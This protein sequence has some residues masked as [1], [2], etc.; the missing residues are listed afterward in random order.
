MA[1]NI[2]NEIAGIDLGDERRNRRIGRLAA[3]MAASPLE[4]LRAACK[5]WAEAIAGFRLLHN[6]EVTWEKILCAHEQATMERAGACERMLL[7][8]DT[9]ELDYSSHKALTGAGRLDA[10]TRQGFYAHNH[11]LVDEDTGVA[12]GLCGSHVWSREQETKDHGHKL[13]PF[14]EKESYRWFQGYQRACEVAKKHPAAEVVTV[15]DRESDIYEIY[16]DWQRRC[17]CG[18]KR[19]EVLVRAGRDRALLDSD[20]HLFQT[21]RAGQELGTYQVKFASK[22]QLRKIK[23]SNHL[24][25]RLGRKAT[26]QVRSTKVCLKPPDRKHGEKLPSVELWAVCILEIDPPQGHE[27]I[28]WFLLTS[29]PAETFSRAQ[30]IISAYASRWLVEELHRILKSGCRVER[31][32]L[33]DSAALLPAV[34]LYLI[35]AWR[36]L[37]L[38]DFRRAQ[39]DLCC[40][41]FFTPAE[42]QAACL[43]S[44]RP[45]DTGPPT[46]VLMVDM[47]G[48]MGGH[49]GRKNDPSPGPEC[50]WRGM[51]KLRCYVEMGQALGKF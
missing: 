33:R 36:I 46:L 35:V 18:E 14:E 1:A 45:T 48:K 43:I 13:V 2:L 7:I 6:K 12:L 49:M 26:L 44:G 10:Q 24:T 19:A 37:Y 8:Q 3:R 27:P 50:L 42:W 39:P 38:R 41:I 4:S 15:G 51:E 34:A 25:Q 20:K 11:L 23:G 9:T 21:M 29:L 40:S 31:V 5:G 32:N 28:E 17:R 30:R 16:A 22:A 47:V